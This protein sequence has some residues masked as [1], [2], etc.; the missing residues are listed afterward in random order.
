VAGRSLRRTKVTPYPYAAPYHIRFFGIEFVFNVWIE[1]CENILEIVE[2]QK[3]LRKWNFFLIG[4][5]LY[6]IQKGKKIKRTSLTHSIN[7]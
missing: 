3:V 1:T 4:E 2:Q 6:K 5:V 7:M